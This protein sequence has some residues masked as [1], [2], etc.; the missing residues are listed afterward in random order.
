MAAR[1]DGSVTESDRR[2]KRAERRRRR[3]RSARYS[4][5]IAPAGRRLR[6]SSS[7]GRYFAPSA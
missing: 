3:R 6:T 5:F 7:L 4:Y 1:Y 2:V